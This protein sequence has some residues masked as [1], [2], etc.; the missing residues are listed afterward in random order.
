MMKLYKFVRGLARVIF[1]LIYRIRVHGKENIPGDG[2]LIIGA[3]HSHVLDPVVLA[4][5]IPREI[6]FMGKKE[7]FENKFLNYIFTNIGAFPVDRD[8][9]DIKAV[10]NSLRVLQ[11]DGVL[12][13]FP[14]GTRVTGYDEDNAKAGMAMISLRAKSVILP[15]YIESSY[16][17]FSRIDVYIGEPIDLS[18]HYGERLSSEEYSKISKDI[19]KKIYTIK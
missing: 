11:N 13:I 16:R 6:S 4:L 5:A 3:N 10:K 2:R 14:E 15:V 12:G 9:T 17:I 19:L 1:K 8:G 18:E 7:L